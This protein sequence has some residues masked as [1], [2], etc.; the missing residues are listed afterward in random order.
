M[1]REVHK[2]TEAGRNIVT[3]FSWAH[4]SRDNAECVLPGYSG[5]GRYVHKAG[6]RA[7]QPFSK[8]V[9]LSDKGALSI[10]SVQKAWHPARLNQWDHPL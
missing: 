7:L 1:A 4:A 10:Q 5:R 8:R 3:A 2:E 9:N 6:S